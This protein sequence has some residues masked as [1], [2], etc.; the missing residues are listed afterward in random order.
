MQLQPLSLW[1]LPK[2]AA[3]D[4]SPHGDTVAC[5]QR[6]GRGEDFHPKP[7]YTSQALAKYAAAQLAVRREIWRR[8]RIAHLPLSGPAR[9]DELPQRPDLLERRVPSVDQFNPAV[10]A[11]QSPSDAICWGH[12][13]S[14]D[15][16]HWTDLPIA[17]RPDTPWDRG[18]V[19][20][21]NTVAVDDK[22]AIAVHT[23]NISGHGHCYAVSATSTDGL[24]T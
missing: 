9:L 2:E 3:D 18:G 4:R 10:H 8:T 14:K 12:A 11:G 20:S 15:P 6:R 23:G 7:P 24:L 22:T 5:A 19:Y 1:P 17:M 16:V 21:G 13:K